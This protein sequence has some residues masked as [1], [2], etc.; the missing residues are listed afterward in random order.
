MTLVTCVT[1]IPLAREVTGT[2]PKY[3]A[4]KLPHPT[5]MGDNEYL[6]SNGANDHI[7]SH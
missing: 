7:C 4:G 1:S 2:K 3:T 6:L 5:A